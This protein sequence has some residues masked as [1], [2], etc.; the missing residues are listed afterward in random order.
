MKLPVAPPAWPELLNRYGDQIGAILS[1]Q[2]GAEVRG[3]YEHWD[4]LR[5]LTPPAG[6]NAEQWWLQ[7]TQEEAIRDVLGGLR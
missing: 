3:K 7:R 6:L 5:H 2:L 4:H 1:N